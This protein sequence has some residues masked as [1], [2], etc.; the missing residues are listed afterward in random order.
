MS[1]TDFAA[2]FE[3]VFR[4][5]NAVVNESLY[6]SPSLE[7]NANDPVLKAEMKMD[8]AC[9]LLN[10]V[11]SASA[12][13]ETPDFWA[14]MDLLDAVPECESATRLLEKLLSTDP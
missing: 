3:R 11:A 4:H 8:H 14:R 7:H 6:A 1:E 5:H 12:T 13:G 2:Y 9:H 10:E